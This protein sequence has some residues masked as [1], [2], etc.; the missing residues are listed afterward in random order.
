MTQASKTMLR[1]ASTFSLPSLTAQEVEVRTHPNVAITDAHVAA[2][3]NVNAVAI[4]DFQAV[5][6]PDAVNQHVLAASGVDAPMGG[7]GERHIPDGHVTAA[8]ERQHVGAPVHTVLDLVV[9]MRRLLADHEF[10]ALAVNGACA[11]DGDAAR[12]LGFD[13]HT[14]FAPVLEGRLG[15]QC[16]V[17][18]GHEGGAGFDVQLHVRFQLEWPGDESAASRDQDPSSADGVARVNGFLNG[19]GVVRSAVADGA[20]V[21]DAVG[22]HAMLLPAASGKGSR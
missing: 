13:P 17:R 14:A 18:A 19:L 4:P 20:K 22:R 12:I 16:L 7:V 21:H 1:M 5:Q 11:G 10:G 8:D 3:V 15:I 2:M 6:N 9:V